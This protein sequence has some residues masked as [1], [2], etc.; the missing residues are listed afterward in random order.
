[1]SDHDPDRSDDPE[2]EAIGDAIADHDRQA[3]RQA[4]ALIDVVLLETLRRVDA[5]GKHGGRV[6]IAA[7]HEA[8]GALSPGAVNV[9]LVDAARRGWIGLDRDPATAEIRHVLL[10]EV[11]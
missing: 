7:V 3:D 4:P 9:A 11:V 1:M 10:K 6:P 8:L 2:L 5:A